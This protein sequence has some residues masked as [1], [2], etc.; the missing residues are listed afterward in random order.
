MKRA[1]SPQGLVL[2][3][4]LT[5]MVSYITR[6]N[7]GAIVQEIVIATGFS[8]AQ[9]SMALTG[10]FI[11]YG[12][13]QLLSGVCGD[14]FQPKVLIGLGLLLTT[15]TNLLIPFCGAVGW[16]VAVWCVNGFAQAFMWP[17]LVR[18]MISLLPAEEYAHATMVVAWG[19]SIGTILIYLISPLL[20]TWADWRSVFWCAALSSL[21]MAWIWWRLCP[22]ITETEASPPVK[23]AENRSGRLLS[24]LLIGILLAIVLQGALRDGITTW[25]PTYIAETYQLG[26]GISILSGVLL[27]LFSILCHRLTNSLYHRLREDPLLC[28]SI[29]F[30]AGIITTL[31][32]LLCTGRSAAG[33]ALCAALLTGCMHGINLILVCI[34]PHFFRGQ[35]HISAISGLLNAFTYVGSA[36]ST[37][38]IAWVSE[39]SGWIA[40]IGL[41]AVIAGLGLVICLVCLPAWRRKFPK[42]TG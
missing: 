38:G 12:A 18:L 11:T 1:L 5:Y 8:K 34:V 9:L 10:S 32:L 40:T 41:W 24:P 36:L 20:I 15:T 21:C 33:S 30:A 3:F 35:G 13:G 4:M 19:G 26:S 14:R 31:A 17:P 16:M 7:F 23:T 22:K 6:I 37:Y 39:N 2:L 25:M 42:K 28:S 27:P 29:L